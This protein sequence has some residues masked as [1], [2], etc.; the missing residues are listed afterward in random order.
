MDKLWI[1][2]LWG[3]IAG[4]ALLLGA[5]F[6][7]FIKVPKRVTAGVMAFG[8]GVLISALTVELMLEAVQTGGFAAAAWGFLLGAVIYTIANYFLTKAGAKHRKRSGSQQ[9]DAE[10][11]GMA[12]AVGALIDVSPNR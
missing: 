12:I 5:A 2:G 10:D 1:A 3:L 9:P 8:S 6:G 11:A 4:G 7:Y